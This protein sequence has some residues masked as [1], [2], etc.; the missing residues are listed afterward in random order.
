M[1]RELEKKAGEAF[2][3]EMLK[4]SGVSERAGTWVGKALKSIRTAPGRFTTSVRKGYKGK[5]SVRKPG[6]LTLSQRNVAGGDPLLA[7]SV[8]RALTEIKR[9]KSPF[10]SMRVRPKS[11][12]WSSAPTKTLIK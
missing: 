2:I 11:S 12:V 10:P 6:T 5:P 1:E 4:I 8:Q 3:D 7:T 9:K